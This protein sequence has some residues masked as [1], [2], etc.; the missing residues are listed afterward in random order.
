MSSVAMQ[1][2]WQKV[3]IIIGLVG[4]LI[5]IPKSAIEGWNAILR[6]PHVEIVPNVPIVMTYNQKLKSIECSIGVLVY[7]S[8]NKAE[9]ISPSGVYFGVPNDRSGRL[10][11][12]KNDI[13]L[14]D[15]EHEAYKV[16]AEQDIPKNLTC[17]ITVAPSEIRSLFTRQPTRR[18]FV[19]ELV[20]KNGTHQVSCGF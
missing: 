13:T 4:G 16:L 6:R 8:G 19:L 12:L 10:V 14:K 2:N 7:N 11:F 5:S 1:S 17:E 9:L 3:A 20:N 15:G 18:E